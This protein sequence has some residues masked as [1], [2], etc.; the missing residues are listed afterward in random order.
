MLQSGVIVFR[1]EI[2]LFWMGKVIYKDNCIVMLVNVSMIFCGLCVGSFDIVGW[3]FLIVIEDM[4]GE[5]IVQFVG[6]EVK[7]K[8]GR[9]IKE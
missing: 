4:I 2:G 8:I 3:K 9:I 1:N 5:K 6:I 7:I